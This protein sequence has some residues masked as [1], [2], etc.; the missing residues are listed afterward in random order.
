M[1]ENGFAPFK[2]SEESGGRVFRNGWMAVCVYVNR[3]EGHGIFADTNIYRRIHRN[4]RFKW[5]KGTNL[6]PDDLRQLRGLLAAAEEF[7]G[8]LDL[9]F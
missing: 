3:V 9:N 1:S 7:I 8:Q 6:K 4:G 5:C 2:Q